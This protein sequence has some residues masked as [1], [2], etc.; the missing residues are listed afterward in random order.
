MPVA[1]PPAAPNPDAPLRL[2]Y[3][4]RLEEPQK[5]V[6]RLV[7]VFDSLAK[8]GIPFSAVVAG[9]GPARSAFL[10]ALSR[11]PANTAV[12]C[13]GAVDETHLGSMLAQSDL[14]LL[15][16]SYEGLPLA[17]LEAMAAGVCPVAMR[18]ES[19]LEDMLLPGTNAIVVPQGDVDAMVAD[20][21]GLDR[22]RG[23]LE[24]LKRFAR[25]R[26]QELFAP[27][28]HFR[29]LATVL[30]GCFCGPAPD[31]A[32]V[33]PDP[34]VTAVRTLAEEAKEAM[35]PVVIYGAGMFGR[36]LVDACLARGLDVVGWVDSDPAR[37]GYRYRSLNCTS[38]E[39]LRRWPEAVILVGS[40]EFAEEIR[41]R[42]LAVFTE[43]SPTVPRVVT[44]GDA[45]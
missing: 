24:S 40:L 18:I 2:I 6:S 22:D 38:P 39:S 31:P 28:R 14:F 29:Q 11:S 30:D 12:S 21:A 13:V 45:H 5:R 3:A 25:E 26:I 19:G 23:R 17:L 16:S 27:D 10:E 42:A 35:R 8:Q 37:I 15:T 41:A 36:K 33:A 32:S 34:A 1:A 7:R 9:D 43:Y 44:A 20:I 4:G